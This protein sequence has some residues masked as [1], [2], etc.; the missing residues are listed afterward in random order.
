MALAPGSKVGPYEIV[1]PLGS[2][3]MGE[4][5]TARDARLGRLVALKILPAALAADP[6]LRDRFD[7]EARAIAALT[8]PHIVTIHSIEDHAGAPFL[9]M[10]LVEGK[11][12]TEV[13]PT[14]G[15]SLQELLR[16]AIPLADAVA[17]AH[18]RGITHRDLKPGNVMVGFHGRVKVLDFGLAKLKEGTPAAGGF[19]SLPTEQLTGEGRILG[20]VAYMSPEQAEGKPVDHR[21]D[22]FALGIML[23]ELATG[24]RPFTGDSN[25]AAIVHPAGSTGVGVR[26]QPDDAA[27]AGTHHPPL[28]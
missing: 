22:I 18:Q 13:I 28:P 20:T 25:V 2:G 16:I 4:V 6:E 27:R 21:C 23:Y 19:T 26:R 24:N 12:L 1:S 8:H 17:A 11:T 3:G 9:T 10:E 7:R 15:L 5:Y 14:A